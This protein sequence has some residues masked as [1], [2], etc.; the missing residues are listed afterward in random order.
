M[1]IVINFLTAFLAISSIVGVI[2]FLV[3]QSIWTRYIF[4]IVSRKSK[5]I[6]TFDNGTDV[7]SVSIS[8]SFNIAMES[9][10]EVEND[11]G[12]KQ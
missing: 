5:P 9:F 2:W 4:P 7:M 11:K 3:K 6:I 10:K 1:T 8:T 12:L